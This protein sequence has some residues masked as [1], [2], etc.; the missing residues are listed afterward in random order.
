MGARQALCIVLGAAALAGCAGWNDVTSDAISY[1][2]WPDGRVPGTYVFER[3][4]SQQAQPGLQD[5]LEQSAAPA[6]AAAGFRLAATRGDADVVVQI[7]ARITRQDYYGPWNDPL[8]WRGYGYG[9]YWGGPW[10]GAY[11][12]YGPYGWNSMWTNR[13]EYER[14]VALMLRDRA[15]GQPLYEARARSDSYT[16]GSTAVLSAMY[17]AALAGF[18]HASNTS[19]RVTVPLVSSPNPEPPR[20]GSAGPTAVPP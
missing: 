1:G 18:P 17:N 5:S 6:L 20:A 10:A 13:T 9:P 3:S 11:G 7:G 15:T 14:E 2:V 12:R 16:S 19:K 4:P 8:W